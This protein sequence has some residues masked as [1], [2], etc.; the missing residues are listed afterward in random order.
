MYILL[1]CENQRKERR[2]VALPLSFVSYAFE[3]DKR[4][5][6]PPLLQAKYKILFKPK[7]VGNAPLN[8]I[9]KDFF[10]VKQWNVTGN[11]WNLADSNSWKW[12]TLLLIE[13]IWH[14]L[15][16]WKLINILTAKLVNILISTCNQNLLSFIQI[17]YLTLNKWKYLCNSLWMDLQKNL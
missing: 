14:I 7:S 1:K 9:S 8:E 16:F 13:K 2:A 6:N 17:G 4:F 11:Q 12:F 3:K 10:T 15:I 5:L